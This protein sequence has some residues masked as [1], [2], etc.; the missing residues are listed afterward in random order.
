MDGSSDR[1]ARIDRV[2]AWHCR[3]P[4][5]TPLQLGDI[6]IAQRDFVIVRITTADGLEGVAY[7]LSRGGP[8]D[9][10]ATD[11]LAPLVLG[12]SALDIP[13]RGADMAHGTLA[14]GGTGI[15]QRALSLVDLCLW[16][17]KARAVGLPVWRLL[18]GYREEAPVLLV[19]PYVEPMESHEDY[20]A[21]L[22]PSVARGYRALKLYP[23]PDVQVMAGRLAAMRQAFGPEIGLVVDMAWA[24][25][26]P[27]PAI[28]AVTTWAPFDLAWVED[29]M[30]PADWRSIRRLARGVDTPIGA[31]DDVS[32]PAVIDALIAHSAVGVLRLD[33]T[34]IGGFTEFDRI[35]QV[36]TAAGLPVSPHA[37]PEI[38]R[39]CVFAWPGVDPIEMFMPGSPT[40]GASVLLEAEDDLTPGRAT[41]S[42][43]TEPGLGLHLDWDGVEGHAIRRS[44]VRA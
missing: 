15:V 42:A 1:T 14:H 40:W 7:A 19:A 17:I 36:A 39:H 30:P 25:R 35:R 13:R 26:S 38:H 43:P 23:E 9:V 28:H 16:D 12:R 31:G 3:V 2:E 21:R 10:A 29:P 32:T 34:T 41:L 4:L 27:R 20:A 5:A 33:A 6:R 18:G 8:V 44:S 24:W 22:A 37:Y 11:L